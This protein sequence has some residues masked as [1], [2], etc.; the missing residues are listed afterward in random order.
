MRN[1]GRPYRPPRR[2]PPR[3]PPPPPLRRGGPPLV[4][5]LKVISSDVRSD[6]S[7]PSDGCLQSDS[8][9]ISPPAATK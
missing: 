9:G 4:A 6:A 2:G 3:L 7:R 1:E 8:V 5:D